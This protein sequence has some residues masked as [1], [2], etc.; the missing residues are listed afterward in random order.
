MMAWRSLASTVATASGMRPL[1]V[2]SLAGKDRPDHRPALHPQ[3]REQAFRQPQGCVP[4]FVDSRLATRKDRAKY[5]V[6]FTLPGVWDGKRKVQIG[7]LFER[8]HRGLEI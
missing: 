3:R 5:V 6:G 4:S 7:K 1:S 2:P 8:G